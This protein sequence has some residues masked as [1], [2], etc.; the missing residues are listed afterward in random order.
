VT[1][2]PGDILYKFDSATGVFEGT[3]PAPTVPPG[4]FAYAEGP[5]ADTALK[6]STTGWSSTEGHSCPGS[7]TMTGAFT[8]YGN[9][10]KLM[11]L[12]NFNANW[13]TPKA[14]VRLHAWVKVQIPTTGTLDLSSVHIQA[15]TNNF[16][17][18]TESSLPASTFL[19]GDWHEITHALVVGTNYVPE[20][21]N[22]MGIQIFPLAAGTDT[23][24]PVT[25]FIDDIW[26]ELP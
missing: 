15:N 10:D 26:L 17:G 5:T 13:A 19:D 20:N 22:Q 24:V 4:W 3:V 11:A 16:T 7:L 8:A 14:Y 23:P 1:T 25:I 6:A 21:V 2:L 12:V 9:G 18:Y